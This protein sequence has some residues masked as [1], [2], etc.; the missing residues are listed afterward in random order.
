MKLTSQIQTII[1]IFF[2][3]LAVSFYETR[4]VKIFAV[5]IENPFFNSL[6]SAYVEK[7][8]NIKSFFDLRRL[9]NKK[10]GLLFLSKISQPI[11]ANAATPPSISGP[12]YNILVVGDSFIA[13]SFGPFLEKEL[14]SFQDVKVFRK[15]VYST[16]LS[17]ADYFDWEEE[18]KKLILEKKP[19]IVF[20]KFGA[21]DGQFLAGYGKK[22]IRYGSSNW[23]EEYGNRVGKILKILDDNHIYTF[24]IGNP[25]ARGEDYL[26]KM[27]KIN[28]IYRDICK[29]SPNCLYL[30]MWNVLATTDGAYSAYLPDENGQKRLARASDGIHTTA[31]GS[32]L[33]LKKIMRQ[34]IE[35]IKLQKIK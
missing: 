9:F 5:E 4:R 20:A 16:G 11:I 3:L 25:I 21:N 6:V 19:N 35:Q 15:G 27:A 28:S 29:D 13:E 33:I 10:D 1:I 23:S 2:V 30:D 31:F 7:A 18:M 32:Q 17:R 12:P 24:W 26:N 34:V 22:V 8:E 14:L